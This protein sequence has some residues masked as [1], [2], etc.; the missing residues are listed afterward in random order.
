MV[1]RHLHCTLHE[2]GMLVLVYVTVLLRGAHYAIENTHGLIL[3][4]CLLRGAI[5]GLLCVR[6]AHVFSVLRLAI[7]AVTFVV[8]NPAVQ[9]YPNHSAAAGRGRRC[10]IA[11]RKRRGRFRS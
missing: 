3:P 7:P 10:I 4:S 5:P 8:I 2:A 1:P 6:F 9:I 11:L